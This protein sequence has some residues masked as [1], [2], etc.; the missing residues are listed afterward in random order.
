MAQQ[1]LNSCIVSVS[2][3]WRLSRVISIGGVEHRFYL[4]K[5]VWGNGCLQACSSADADHHIPRRLHYANQRCQMLTHADMLDN[6]KT[7][8]IV[9]PHRPAKP[10]PG[11]QPNYPFPVPV[12]NTG[13][14]PPLPPESTDALTHSLTM[15][16]SPFVTPP[17]APTP[18]AAPPAPA[19]RP[20]RA[21]ATLPRP[22]VSAE[23]PARPSSCAVRS[24]RLV[25]PLM[26]S[27]RVSSL[28]WV[29]LGGSVRDLRR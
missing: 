29:G 18:L 8:A 14:Y 9:I 15:P 17:T 11:P 20:L 6:Y 26:R 21:S 7:T 19:S 27:V 16:V 23:L 12:R 24:S 4:G 5:H 13:T 25:A 3:L 1:R 22:V 2:N 28:G 10:L